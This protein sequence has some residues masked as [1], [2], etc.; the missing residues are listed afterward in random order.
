MESSCL[1][2]LHLLFVFPELSLLVQVLQHSPVETYCVTSQTAYGFLSW[3]HGGTYPSGLALHPLLMAMKSK[4]NFQTP[5]VPSDAPSR[6]G[7][8]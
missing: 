8:Q 1:Q 7:N 4:Q 6:H 3:V 2:T 5:T